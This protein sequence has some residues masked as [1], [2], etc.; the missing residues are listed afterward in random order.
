MN[1]AA[2]F[3]AFMIPGTIFLGAYDV[4][5]R[6]ILKKGVHDGLLLG[7]NMAV[8]GVISFIV[9]FIFGFPVIKK[10]FWLALFISMGLNIISQRLWYRAFKNAEA[11]LISPF[12]LLIPPL[13]LLTGFIFLREVPTFFGVL[14]ICVTISG[15]WFLLYGHEA[16]KGKNIREAFD[17][18][19]V[20]YALGGAVL[21][22]IS[23]PWDK[24]AVVASSALF[25]GAFVFSGIG[26]ATLIISYFFR[27]RKQNISA[28]IYDSRKLIALTIILYTLGPF[29]NYTAL[30]YA[31]VSYASAT[32]QISSLWAI[33]LSGQILE[34]KNIAKKLFAAA[35]MLTGVLIILTLG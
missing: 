20:H 8:T 15:L 1:N 31:L 16:F 32:K 19:V 7:I 6:K 35:V 23:F 30:K 13:V 26:I 9:L 3:L 29:F 14:G 34:E 10:G 22:A 33:L 5:V 4:F 18:P 11:S 17:N 28:G 21:W 12:K 24:K 25:F 2:L 27:T